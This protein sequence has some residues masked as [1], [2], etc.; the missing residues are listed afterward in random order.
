MNY[1]EFGFLR[2]EELLFDNFGGGS[3]FGLDVFGDK[4][5]GESA[6]AQQLAFFV[7]FYC[8]VTVDSGYFFDH[9][10]LAFGDDLSQGSARAFLDVLWH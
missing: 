2:G 8:L 10:L 7:L 4:A 1:S 6:F 9:I 5:I 3:L